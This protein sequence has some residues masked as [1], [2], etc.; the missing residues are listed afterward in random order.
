MIHPF[1]RTLATRPELLAEHLGAYAHLVS[2]EAGETTAQLRNQ[3][4]WGLAAGLCLVLTLGLGGTA[5]LLVAA[6][7]IDEM[8]APWLLAV[9]PL[10]P[11]LAT[12]A[13]W[14]QMRR[15]PLNCSFELL[16]QQV[17]LDTAL[18]REASEA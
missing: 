11:C 8:P 17:A 16:R 9:V 7:P 2:V 13:C 10:V 12:L 6:V 15:R 5:L 14:W 3:A 4:V 18:L 1:F